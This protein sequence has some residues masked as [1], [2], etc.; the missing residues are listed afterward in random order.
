MYKNP[1]VYKRPLC[2]G[3]DDLVTIERRVLQEKASTSL[4]FGQWLSVCCAKK[5]GKT[6]FLLRLMHDCRALHP[7]WRFVMVRAE[8]FLKFTLDELQYVLQAK[9]RAEIAASSSQFSTRESPPG[10]NRE[11]PHALS[12]IGRELK[13]GQRIIFVLD[14]LEN[15]PREFFQVVLRELINLFH[16]QDTDK[17]LAKFQFIIAGCLPPN[18][19]RLDNG[20]SF[21]EYATKTFLEDFPFEDVE[22]MV[23]KA[24]EHLEVRCQNGFTRLIYE[25]TSGTGYL[26]QKICYKILEIAFLRKVSPEFT[27]KSGEEAIQ[28]I[29]RESE[30]NV[31]VIIQQVEKKKSLIEGL[32]RA[33]RNGTISSYKFDPDLQTLVSIG[34]LS[35]RNGIYR[36]RNQIFEKIFQ[37]YFTAERLANRYY[38]EKNYHRA[39]E[40]FFDAIAQQD[41]ARNALENLLVSVRAIGENANQRDFVTRILQVFADSVEG[42]QNC[43]LFLLDKHNN[44]MK[45]A[46]A[47]GLSPDIVANFDLDY[48][49]GV[50]GLV[51]Q[52]GRTRVIRDVTDE[53]ECPEFVARDIAQ[54]LNIGAMLSMPLRIGGE[55]LGVINLCLRKPH[56]FT[57][58]EIKMLEI[59]ATQ[60]SI[61]LQNKPLYQSLERHEDYFH[62]LSKSIES[63]EA[64]ID[65]ELV[66]ENILESARRITGWEKTYIVCKNTS[67][68]SWQFV[69]PKKLAQNYPT[70]RTPEL[71]NGEGTAGVVLK[72]GAPYLVSDVQHNR[73]YFPMWNDVSFEYATPVV[74]DGEIV[75]CL[76]VAGSDFAAF[77]EIHQ[78]ILSSLATLTSLAIKKQRLYGIAEKQTQQVITLKAIGEVISNEKR[79]QELLNLIAQECLKVVERPDKT[80]FI[81]LMDKV[82]DRLMV[83][84]ASGEDESGRDYIGMSLSMKERGVVEWVLG[85]KEPCFVNDLKN[86]SNGCVFNPRARSEIAVPLIFHGEILG[87]IDVQSKQA[88][89]FDLLDQESLTAV[90]NN[91]AVAIKI[92]ELCNRRLIEL[93]ALYGIGKKISSSINVG[94]ILRT[95]CREALTAI[96]NENRN[97]SVQILHPEEQDW[98]LEL[99]LGPG[100]RDAKPSKDILEEN[101]MLKWAIENKRHLLIPN[102]RE[103][104]MYAYQHSGMKSA[105]LVPIIFDERFIG[106]IT[107]ESRL[108]DDFGENELRLLKGLANQAGVALENARL[109]QNLATTQLQLSNELEAVAIEAA[110]A[111]LVH[112]IKNISTQIA[113]ET[114]WLRKCENGNKLD[115]RQVKSAIQN[116]NSYVMKV[117]E[118]TDSVR[119]RA[120]KLPPELKR[121]NLKEVVEEACELVSVK[122][123][124]SRVDICW[125][126]HDFD[127]H[128]NVDSGRLTRAFFNIMTNAIDAMPGGG[129]LKIRAQKTEAYL[130]IDFTDTG[131]GIQPEHLNKVLSPFITTKEEGYGLGLAITRRIVEIDHKG[132]LKLQSIPGQ[133]TTVS[134]RIPLNSNQTRHTPREV[135]ARINSATKQRVSRTRKTKVHILVVNDEKGM[136]EKIRRKLRGAGYQ[137]TGTEYGKKAVALCRRRQFSAI[138]LDYHL[139]KD[140]SPTRTALDFLP[141]IRKEFPT[142]PIILTSASLQENPSPDNEYDYFLEI[143]A[144]FWD[145]ILPLLHTCLQ[146]SSNEIKCS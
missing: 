87:V 17:T 22:N 49:E 142:I 29:I 23:Q 43:S 32:I 61:A 62:A 99:A 65:S 115:L 16:A 129:A 54:K 132:K 4:K 145:E 107:M 50:A 140:T 78:I 128:L 121:Q 90:A 33:M 101:S 86:G 133:G 71:R 60:V 21:S 20:L 26:I 126:E 5:T 58:S 3:R 27:L 85:H 114:Q 134:V 64:H 97:V 117:E 1:F 31:E 77:S 76:A 15:A 45:I 74:S 146:V 111:G 122:A 108:E 93:E 113:G 47:L 106:M 100:S 2:P 40:L 57:H 118:L 68:N 34:A 24:A 103:E 136:L 98:I 9:L 120:Y 37:D 123:L 131:R 82:R 55:V 109:S 25:M 8:D 56:E 80:A 119:N 116:I 44:H 139:K 95:I 66:F 75:G 105:V 53:V 91:A 28:S 125:A 144:A 18:E 51:A 88:G 127:I 38:A 81:L 35:H 52:T 46:E 102:V 94:E 112:D 59:M 11:I 67:T 7:N 138:I 10:E 83:R 42:V 135:Q 39:K 12:M 36:L 84:A 124:R 73:Q 70:L 19:L 92:S 72:T 130:E 110:L 48:G 137:V 63:L 41:N 69:F 89:S 13:D 96:G 143:N 141:E 30:T 14:G 6:S 104:S 79:E